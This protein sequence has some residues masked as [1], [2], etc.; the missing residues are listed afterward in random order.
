M[1]KTASSLKRVVPVRLDDVPYQK[2]R[3]LAVNAGTSTS[4]FASNIVRAYI[5]RK[6][7]DFKAEI[8]K[9]SDTE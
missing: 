3:L 7:N 2:L 9:L 8:E 5:N 6:F 1:K 4:A